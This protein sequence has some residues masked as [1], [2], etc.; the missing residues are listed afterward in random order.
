[1]SL[2]KSFVNKT[3][4]IMITIGD[5]GAY[6]ILVKGGQVSQKFFVSELN[7]RAYF[8]IDTFFKIDKDAEVFV[9]IDNVEQKFVQK[10]FNLIGSQGLHKVIKERLLKEFPDEQLKAYDTIGKVDQ[11]SWL[12]TFIACGW[13]NNLNNWISLILSY[14][15]VL[16]GVHLLPL[17]LGSVIKEI[18]L[19]HR[20]AW[21]IMIMQHKCSGIR[22][23][24]YCYDK[25]ITSEVLS[26]I[27]N[28]IEIIGENI[29][30][31]IMSM[32]QL[33]HDLG[34]GHDL[35]VNVI[36]CVSK[37]IAAAVKFDDIKIDEW[38]ILNKKELAY[39]LE[40]DYWDRE[41][42]RSVDLVIMNYFV[43]RNP[44]L[45]MSLISMLDQSNY[46]S[47]IFLLQQSIL[48][49][50]LA[51]LFMI[52]VMFTNI[53]DT[54]SKLQ[55]DS[56]YVVNIN[57]EIELKKRQQSELES[58]IASNIPLSKLNE[59][60]KS[61]YILQMHFDSPL[62]IL[63]GL[64]KSFNSAMIMTDFSWSFNDPL[65]A[66]DNSQPPYTVNA[67]IEI[68]LLEKEQSDKMSEEYKLFQDKLEALLPNYSLSF[69]DL[70]E[71]K[72]KLHA[73]ITVSNDDS[74]HN[75]NEGNQE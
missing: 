58:K 65:F 13:N 68:A 8:E 66:K 18:P 43:R 19:N 70:K 24:L 9:Y 25:L 45:R 59:I 11:D 55:I 20:K 44:K 71:D 67:A 49:I 4:K 33:R 46:A 74:R 16:K 56:K 42:D 14:P 73:T 23:S 12:V 28:D 63:S 51:M 15:N 48:A 21:N 36:L 22:I 60:I 5:L 40:T 50:S 30:L 3:N 69:T 6:F 41:E 2:I 52:M 75:P 10:K 57:H 29:E 7:E 39:L 27:E 1:M 62:S 31:A 37:N 64:A 34:V 54:Y 72:D 47:R 38:H 26:S 61:I 35:K 17:E 53:Y 32:L